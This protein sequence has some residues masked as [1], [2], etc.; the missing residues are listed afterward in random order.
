MSETI[1]IVTACDNAYAQHA[2]VFLRSLFV[3][4]S[5]ACFRIFIIVPDNFVHHEAIERTVGAHNACV[6]FLSVAANDIG[7]VKI[8]H[9]VTTASYFRLLVGSLL[10]DHVE[11]IIFFDPDIVINGPI[12][13]LWDIDLQDQVLAAAVDVTQNPLIHAR[14]ELSATSQYFNS[15]VLVINLRRWKTD[16]IGEQAL[17]F[18]LRFPERIS[19]SEQCALNHVL[20]GD[21]KKLPEHWN[22]QMGRL[23]ATDRRKYAEACRSLRS[24]AV[25]HFS[26]R[27]KPWLYLSNHPMKWLYWK[28]LRQTEWRSYRPP[29]RNLRNVG[30]R[31]I[32]SLSLNA[33]ALLAAMRRVR[34]LWRPSVG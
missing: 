20:D 10:P 5:D 12:R 28:Y 25:I 21:F 19:L 17:E 31:I 27:R 2:S 32:W 29:D 7:P 18:A 8:T 24:A 14:L 15:G 1:T 9:Y 22:F 30:R 13:E 6:Q 33:P 16:R 3:Q 26:G 34:S 4:N 23:P 11:R